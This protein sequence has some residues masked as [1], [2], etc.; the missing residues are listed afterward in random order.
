MYWPGR[1][2]GSA[3][4]SSPPPETRRSVTGRGL[5][6]RRS[7]LRGGWGASQPKA[8]PYPYPSPRVESRRVAS[9]RCLRGGGVRPPGQPASQRRQ[10]HSRIPAE[11]RR[12]Q[13]VDREREREHGYIMYVHDARTVVVGPPSTRPPQPAAPLLGG[14]LLSLPQP[15]T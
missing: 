4:P 9:P 7:E 5:S 12:S 15:R 8:Y 2:R 14:P 3:G 1:D 10:G 11:H 13:R 6:A